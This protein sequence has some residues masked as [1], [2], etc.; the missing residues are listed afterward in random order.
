MT[1]VRCCS[2]GWQLAELTRSADRA[3]RDDVRRAAAAGVAERRRARD[4]CAA[5]WRLPR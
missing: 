3:R 1:W 2:C 4:G 5:G